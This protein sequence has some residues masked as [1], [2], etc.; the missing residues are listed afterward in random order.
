MCGGLGGV[1]GFGGRGNRGAMPFTLS[2][3]RPGRPGVPPHKMEL[4]RAISASLKDFR[5][6]LSKLVGAKLS[7]FKGS[8]VV[9]VP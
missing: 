2:P 4:N 5:V 7:F 8:L 3:G 1:G 9:A 6:Q